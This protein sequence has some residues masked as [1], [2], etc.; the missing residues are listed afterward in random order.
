MESE[1]QRSREHKKSQGTVVVI[2]CKEG[3]GT[4]YYNRGSAARRSNVNMVALIIR[5]GI[6]RAIRALWFRLMPHGLAREVLQTRRWG[7]GMREKEMKVRREIW[8]SDGR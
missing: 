2:D 7:E 4:I 5:A 1:S 8:R 3:K 6:R